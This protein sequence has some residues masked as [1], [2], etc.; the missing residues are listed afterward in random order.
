M[1]DPTTDLLKAQL[2][3]LRLPAMVQELEKLSREA[4][5]AN[6]NYE[7]FLLQLT[8]I[9]LAARAANALATRIKNAG[10]PGL[11]GLRHLRFHRAAEPSQAEGL[12]AGPWG[13]DSREVQRQPGGEHRHGK[14]AP[15]HRAWAKRRVV[16]ATEWRSSRRRS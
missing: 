3:L 12:G 14:D 16:K 4:A 10:V 5:A 13:M 11:E 15:G 6:Q 2:K 8:E 1:T 9:E 7:Q